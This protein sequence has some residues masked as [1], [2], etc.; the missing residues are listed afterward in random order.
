[1]TRFQKIS[2]FTNLEEIS[3]DYYDFYHLFYPLSRGTIFEQKMIERY[4]PERERS[5]EKRFHIETNALIE[6]L[7]RLLLSQEH[8]Y[9][10]V[11]RDVQRLKGEDSCFFIYVLIIKTI[12]TTFRFAYDVAGMY[13]FI[14]EERSELY[15]GKNQRVRDSLTLK[16]FTRFFVENDIFFRP[17]EL[18][19]FFFRLNHNKANEEVNCK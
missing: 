3:I 8:Y 6:N 14:N 17:E 2:R 15:E 10:M 11:R 13:E 9:E 5:K 18:K 19:L 12:Q 16:R 1:M 4:E 7:L